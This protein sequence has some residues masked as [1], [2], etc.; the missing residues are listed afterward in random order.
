MRQGDGKLMSEFTESKKD[1]QNMETATNSANGAQAEEETVADV[2]ATDEEVTTNAETSPDEGGESAEKAS[3]EAETGDTADDADATDEPTTMDE[4]VAMAEQY[5]ETMRTLRRGEIIE[6]RVVEVGDD[7]VTVYVGYKSEGRV[8]LNEL[9][10]KEGQTPADVLERDDKILVQVLRVDDDE[11]TVLL[12]RRRAMER[13]AWEELVEKHEVGGHL[14]AEVTARVKGGLLVDIG[15]RGFVPA[16]HVDVSFVDNLDEYVGQT[17]RFR[18]IELDR[19]RRNVV[20]SRRE[21]LEEEL[22]QAKEA[23]FAELEEGQVISGVVRRLTDFGAFVDV[24][25]GVEGLL[26]VSEIAWSRVRHPEDV[27]EE[28]Q[29]VEVKVLAVD[30]ERERISLSIKATLPDPW[31]TVHE[32]YSQ[33]QI[34]EGE[35]TRTVDFGAFVKLEDGIEGLVHISQLS[36]ER[37]ETPADVVKPGEEVK[38][39][40]INLDPD[41]RRIGL[42]IRQAKPRPAAPQRQAPRGPRRQASRPTTDTSYT[43]PGP[44]GVTIGDMVEGLSQLG[45]LLHKQ[46]QEND[47][48]D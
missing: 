46:E 32:R 35:V 47:R 29:E 33:G 27:L 15:V 30:K 34:V 24:G 3:S 8:P 41:Q 38:V 36:D 18:I 25:G 48:E 2:A 44:E 4:A 26:H 45:E 7:D 43:D 17:L 40:V 11:G 6:G 31:T 37:V 23:A 42:S 39:K 16:S 19:Q 9:G 13:E 14:E 21:L 1:E 28:G 10:L 22:A 20:L 5:D 12:S